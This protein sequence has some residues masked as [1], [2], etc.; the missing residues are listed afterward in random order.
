M[1]PRIFRDGRMSLVEMTIDPRWLRFGVALGLLAL[2][3][4]SLPAG[5]PSSKPPPL[6][7]AT[8]R[9]APGVAGSDARVAA[10]ALDTDSHSRRQL[11]ATALASR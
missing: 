7:T 4:L 1:R 10:E 2:G 6:P 3:T 5:S 9:S 8:E 11:L